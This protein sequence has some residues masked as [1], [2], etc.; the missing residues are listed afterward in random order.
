[1]GLQVMWIALPGARTQDH[2]EE[3]GPNAFHLTV[4][5]PGGSLTG[6]RKEPRDRRKNNAHTGAAGN[7]NARG[8]H[9]CWPLFIY[10][11]GFEGLISDASII[12]REDYYKDIPAGR[13]IWSHDFAE[14]SGLEWQGKDVIIRTGRSSRACISSRQPTTMRWAASPKRDYETYMDLFNVMAARRQT[15]NQYRKSG[16]VTNKM[17][18][19]RDLE[20]NR[21]RIDYILGFIFYKF[22]QK[23]S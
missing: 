4:S 3:R 23:T 10:G 7:I 2:D 12:S 20:A 9:R 22:F 1:M 17:Q 19:Q 18:F 21:L 13:T 14:G 5:E 16:E 11:S 15:C 8:P 6:T